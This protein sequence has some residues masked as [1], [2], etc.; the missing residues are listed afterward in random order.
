M[1]QNCL[2]CK[3]ELICRNSRPGIFLARPERTDAD[4]DVD[5]DDDDDS[6]SSLFP[7]GG[8][9]IARLSVAVFSQLR[10]PKSD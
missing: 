7:P 4:A 1:D 9:L 8:K 2:F 10:P 3:P 6:L 5:A